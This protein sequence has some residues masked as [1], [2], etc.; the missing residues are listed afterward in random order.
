MQGGTVGD[1]MVY[2]RERVGQSWK[3]EGAVNGDALDTAVTI[4]SVFPKSVCWAPVGHSTSDH[5]LVPGSSTPE[6]NV[7]PEGFG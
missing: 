7:R 3:R 1:L 2:V 5:D 4:S 6:A